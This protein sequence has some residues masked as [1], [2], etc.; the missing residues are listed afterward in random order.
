MIFTKHNTI[1]LSQAQQK[2]TSVTTYRQNLDDLESFNPS[3]VVDM[4]NDEL[5]AVI[6][7]KKHFCLLT[8]TAFMKV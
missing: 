7:R 3:I 1:T 8:D 6:N 4:A 2:R 5:N